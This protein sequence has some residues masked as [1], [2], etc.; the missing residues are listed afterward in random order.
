MKNT[1]T[2]ANFTDS[3]KST[4]AVA[5]FPPYIA[6]QVLGPVLVR[7][8]GPINYLSGI[9]F[10]WGCVMVRFEASNKKKYYCGSELILN[11]AFCGIR[12]EMD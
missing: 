12:E 8:I 9:C 2:H 6:F 4:I 1:K 7:K 5:F 11:L 3:Q 10:V